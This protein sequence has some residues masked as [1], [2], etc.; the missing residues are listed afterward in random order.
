MTQLTPYE[1]TQV[2]HIAA[3]KAELP[4]YAGK[5]FEVIRFPFRKIAST[6]VHAAKIPALLIRLAKHMNTEH[7]A[8]EIARRA[9]V[10]NISDLYDKPLEFCDSLAKNV[11]VKA[12]REAM[13]Q[14]VATGIGGLPTELAALP[15][16]LRA[17]LHS[18]VRIGHCYGFSLN[19]TEDYLY[20]LGIMELATIDDPDQRQRQRQR[21]YELSEA[22][23]KRLQ[24]NQPDVGV[25]DL[26]G[27]LI[28]GIAEDIAWES[29]PVYGDFASFAISSLETH[30]LDFTARRVFQERRLRAQGKVKRIMPA[31]TPHRHPI[32]R[33]ALY[34]GKEMIYVSSYGSAFIV[35]LPVVAIGA[36]G[37]RLLPRPIVRGLSDGR[38]DGYAAASAAH[39]RGA[40]QTE[41]ASAPINEA[42]PA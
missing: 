22:K 35:A 42:A 23:R 26:R 38:K 37:A 18:V 27:N 25:D 41:I 9:G 15:L 12:E 33:D 1:A 34:L 32:T 28:E 11:S 10:A 14:G 24:K 13:I 30:R 8:R 16:T 5:V 19:A 40:D 2:A 39:E 3:W 4:S 21:L 17:S 20:I 36:V 31:A 29:V 7:D 6:T